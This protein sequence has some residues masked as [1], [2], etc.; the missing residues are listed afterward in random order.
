MSI[1]DYTVNQL[2][3]KCS[4]GVIYNVKEISSEKNYSMGI[5]D[6]NNISDEKLKIITKEIESFSKIE[7][8]WFIKL[9]KY[10]IE[11]EKYYLIFELC[12]N[13]LDLEIKKRN[14][15]TIEEIK[16]ILNQ[17]NKIFIFMNSNKIKYGYLDLKPNNILIKYINNEKT[18]FI[19]KLFE[20]N[21]INILTLND[22]NIE[23]ENTNSETLGFFINETNNNIKSILWN[24]GILIS[25]M[26]FNQLPF[27]KN[28]EKYLK[29]EFINKISQDEN[30]KN[31]LENLLKEKE[32]ERLSW[33]EYF[34]HP[35]FK[36]STNSIEYEKNLIICEIE[37]KKDKVNEFIQILNCYDETKK[38]D[39]FLIGVENEKEIKDKCELFLDNN[40][41][42]FCFKYKFLSEGKYKIQIIFDQPLKNSNYLF[43]KCFL[44]N[45]LDLSNFIS[46]DILN[47]NGM[48]FNCSYLTSL[49]LTNFNTSNVKDMSYMFR[50]CSSL[51]SLDLL[52]FNTFNVKDM[53][54]MFENCYSLTSLNLSNFNTSNVIS[55]TDMFS[56]CYSLTSLNLS[57]FN[58]INVIN[59]RS[60][61]SRC[62]SLINIDLS[63]FNTCNVWNMSCMFYGCSSLTS[64]NLSNFN[65]SN[66]I[67]IY[68]MFYY[69][70]S[71][72]SL[73]LSNFNTN[74][75]KDM[76][77]MFYYCRSL[78]YLNLSN[79]N[80]SDDINIKDI[81]NS[82]NK[83]CEIITQDKNLLNKIKK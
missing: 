22:K 55:M 64:L 79:F 29:E 81:F 59:M 33:K 49:N 20:N 2:I 32:E 56:Y 67:E 58:T 4:F 48:F 30:L 5:F 34:N 11:K 51:T 3:C 73:D 45:S 68:S 16:E 75:M 71:L 23:K 28:N 44:I 27:D 36:N 63:N 26:L 40:Q 46:N 1:I 69:C 12:D 10:F 76:R 41:I 50:D 8:K 52:S 17:L 82:L 74:N 78:I 6:A 62:S 15:F 13:S 25:Y 54:N 19:I 80:I 39:H 77:N 72:T 66:V 43:Y 35:F 18:K 9:Y 37:I 31:L 47:M 57:N 83:K 53:S 70:R 21:L 14:G 60:M 38:D 7:N 24:I 42:D 65:T 61:F